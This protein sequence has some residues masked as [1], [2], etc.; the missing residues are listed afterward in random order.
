MR[1]IDVFTVERLYIEITTFSLSLTMEHSTPNVVISG[2]AAALDAVKLQLKRS[3]FEL[4]IGPRGAR[5]ALEH[6]GT[7]TV[8]ECTEINTATA[9]VLREFLSIS[10]MIPE[11]QRSVL[12][13]ATRKT[14]ESY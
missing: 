7:L 11:R 4:N 9:D 3:K 2:N 10:N 13:N 1:P 8:E 12:I 6:P 5:F 14:L